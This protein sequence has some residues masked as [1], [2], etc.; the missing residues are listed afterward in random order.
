M[1]VCSGEEASL[2]AI[3]RLLHDDPVFLKVPQGKRKK[4]H[5]DRIGDRD[6]M[7]DLRAL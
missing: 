3:S 1:L 2:A 5:E 4:S 7:G 6:G